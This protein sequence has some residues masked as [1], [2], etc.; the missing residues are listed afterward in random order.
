MLEQQQQQLV[1]GLQEL[2]DLVISNQ[3]WKGT[4]LKE[5]TN[6]HP[7]TH[8]ILERLGALKL[9]SNDECVGFEEDL[10]LLRQKLIIDSAAPQ[11]K[12]STGSSYQNQPH[13]IESSSPKH[14]FDE[15]FPT[16]HQFPPTPPVQSPNE[17]VQT[18]L[19]YNNTQNRIHSGTSLDPSV[20]QSQRQTWMHQ[21]PT[22]YDENLD[23]LRFEQ[24]SGLDS[25]NT[26]HEVTSPCLPISPW[27]DDDPSPFDMNT[28]M[29]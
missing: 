15:P 27:L 19:R 20:L 25:L 16:L 7:L 26:M 23:F 11:R 24:P 3:G 6:G 28:N 5:S 17:Q 9:D 10:D 29:A 12:S 18:S 1:N 2:Y 22:I 21:Q 4:P 14:Y 13:F 8:D